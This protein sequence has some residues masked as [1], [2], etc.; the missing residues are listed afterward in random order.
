MVQIAHYMPEAF[1]GTSREELRR[2]K[3][4]Y[5]LCGSIRSSKQSWM[6]GYKSTD[7]LLDRRQKF[8]AMSTTTPH[9]VSC[10]L[11]NCEVLSH[12]PHLFI[13]GTFKSSPNLFK[14]LLSVHAY[15]DASGHRIPLVYGLLPGKTEAL[16]T[17]FLSCL[18]DVTQFEPQSVLCDYEKGLH[19][20]ILT[21]WPSTSVRG[22][23]FHYKQ[24]LCVY[25]NTIMCG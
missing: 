14:Q 3:Q 4:C 2:W 9:K 21:T 7:P 16:Y 1:N 6:K 22:C 18:D 13:D 15:V 10:S 24:A 25:F 20:A 11:D 5:D 23:F 17:D 19:N 8:S 12:A